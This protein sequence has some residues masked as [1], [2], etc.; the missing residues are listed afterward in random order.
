MP[1]LRTLV[2]DATERLSL[3][4]HP[5]RARQDAEFLIQ[6]LLRRNRAWLLT[7]GDHELST[8]DA[9]AYA[10]FIERRRSG[11]PIQYITREV[12]FYGLT[13]AVTP[14]VL[15]PRPETEHL[16]EKAIK[17][18]FDFSKPRILDIGT[19]S[20]AIAI[21]VAHDVSPYASI[22]ATDISRQALKI[23]RFNARRTGFLRKIRFVQG[24]L[25]A[26]VAEEQFDI[27]VSNPPYVPTADRDSLSVEVRDHEPALA[28]FAGE[29]GLDVYRRLI[30]DAFSALAEGGYLLLE[31][32]Y[33]QSETIA[34]LLEGAGFA[35]VE[36]VPDLQ[37]IPRVACARRPL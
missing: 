28:L 8:A 34:A 33:G 36:I 18:S 3:G 12:E 11:E 10:S 19:G 2:A 22:T 35:G 20:G 30:P 26:P 24:D 1:I 5:D 29:D 23:A 6:H 9:G 25:L 32:G 4:P 7:H 27:I 17:L 13:L 31:I 15:I 16:V 21:A 37:E 14:K